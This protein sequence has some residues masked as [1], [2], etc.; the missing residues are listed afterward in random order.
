MGFIYLLISIAFALENNSLGD[1]NISTVFKDGLKI[2]SDIPH[3]EFKF[4][5]RMQNRFSYEDYDSLDSTK[6]VSDFS[7]RR[8]RLRLDGSV[9]DPRLGFNLQL[10][11]TRG[12]MDWDTDPFPGVLRDAAISWK[13]NNNHI[14]YFGLR[15]LPG[16]RQRVISS[17]QQELVD[18]SL[19]NATFNIDRDYGLQSWHRF[20][21]DHPIWLKM[22]VTNGDGRSRSSQRSGL[23]YTVRAEWLPL[24]D[25]KNGG[26]YFEGDLEYET[27]AKLSLGGVYNLNRQTQRLG[28]QIGS[29]L[30]NSQVRDLENIIADILF[31]YRGWAFSAEYFR[32]NADL[33]QVTATQTI[34]DGV[35]QTAQLSYTFSNHWAPVLRW[36]QIVPDDHLSS[37]LAEREQYTVGITKYIDAHRIKAQVDATW[38]K[39]KEAGS[40]D[41]HNHQFYRVQLEVG[42]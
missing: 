1:N 18:R 6:D 21:E 30:A 9:I 5:F 39:E 23:S 31:K 3:A 16:N 28:G 4:R 24:G 36:T 35:G 20:F 32:R 26:D 22:A 34:Y 27:S 17:G 8:L 7:V 42:I 13:W 40:R 15:K 12:D 14:T 38:E 2:S 19:A 11:F 33:P 37:R 29:L 41:V 10:S 25:F